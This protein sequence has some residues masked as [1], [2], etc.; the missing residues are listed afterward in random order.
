MKD[1]IGVGGGASSVAAGLVHPY[2]PRGKAR[3]ISK[4]R[5]EPAICQLLWKGHEAFNGVRELAVVAEEVA[6][7]KGLDSVFKNQ[8]LLFEART[9]KQLKSFSS[10][11]DNSEIFKI[12][13]SQAL[14]LLPGIGFQKST[15]KEG[16]YGLFIP[17][18]MVIQPTQ[19]MDCL[20]IAC[21]VWS[22]ILLGK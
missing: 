15:Q 17:Q 8:G 7:R 13:Q 1:L 14:D 11:Q 12:T 19:Y 4:S 5:F 3:K 6:N 22:W 18:G 21:Q 10:I 20:W 2:S 9:E 16:L